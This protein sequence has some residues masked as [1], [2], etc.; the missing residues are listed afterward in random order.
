MRGALVALQSIREHQKREKWLDFVE[1]ER[2]RAQQEEQL[3]QLTAR[4]ES[5]RAGQESEEAG[6]LAQ[7]QSWC[8]QMEMRRRNEQRTLET[9][10][11][12]AEERRGHL[13]HARREARIVEL[14]IEQHD[15]RAAA[16]AR[17]A[18]SSFNDELGAQRWWRQCG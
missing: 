5:V 8:L 16:E 9:H 10:T 4:M 1:A 2:V 12:T 6:W 11:R 17:R 3:A 13:E 14:F 7:R 18:E 15:E